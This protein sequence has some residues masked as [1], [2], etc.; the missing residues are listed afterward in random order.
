MK[1][2][3]NMPLVGE[4]PS[5]STD[6]F[7]LMLEDNCLLVDKTLMIKDVIESAD[8]ALLI[9]R[10][11]RFGKTLNL[12]M[13]Q[14][15][16]AAS[17]YGV[18]TQGMFDR[19]QIAKVDNGEFIKKHQGQYPVILI[20]FKDVKEKDCPT[21]MEKIAVLVAEVYRQHRDLLNSDKLAESDRKQFEK[22]IEKEVNT[23]ELEQALR[24]L[25]ECLY[26][27]HGKRV[28][29]LIDEYDTPLSSAHEHKYMEAFNGFMRG[30]LSSAIKSNPYL[31]KAVLTGILRVSKNSML[32]GLNNL[33]TYT[34]F[35]KKYQHYFGF[36]EAEIDELTSTVKID[37]SREDIQRFY[38]GYKIGG[39]VIYNPW[40][41]MSY[42]KSG[43]LLPYWVWTSNDKMFED[44]LLDSKESTKEE[45]ERLI[46]GESIEAKIDTHLRYENLME[47][48]NSLWTLLLFCGYLK[49]EES[50]LSDDGTAARTCQLKIPNEEIMRLFKGVFINWLKGT[51]GDSYE[52][53]LKH[54]I[55]GNVE[56]FTQVLNEFI[57]NSLSFRDVGGDKKTT[58]RFYH[59][60]FI[61]LTANLLAKYHY[62]SNRESGSGVYDVGLVPKSLTNDTGLILEFKH[63][64]L[65]QDLTQLA[66]EAL[67]QIDKMGY[68]TEFRKFPHVKKV[69]KIGLVFS[70]KAV[71]SVNKITEL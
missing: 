40:S 9:V 31:K 23:A 61:G 50:H 18:A 58:E 13:L 30:L 21:V 14:Y 3:K 67:L 32:S 59:G 4:K 35:D 28:M 15:F 6:N 34:L 65:K 7:A 51:M 33:E 44:L 70:E 29:I 43:E 22:Y 25:S 47:D 53:L 27:V 10:P 5:A 2:E 36:T 57:I 55:S 42:L 56:A 37:H 48:P 19:F 45:I 66:E 49:V 12:S 52:A 64:K 17:A 46:L 38:N 24:F 16:F 39:E 63:A 26:Q 41:I 8:S 68:E 20:S 1:F 60:F 62:T 11:R 69:L 71:Q 54:L